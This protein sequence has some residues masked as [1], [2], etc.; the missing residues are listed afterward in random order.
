LI[1]FLFEQLT[2]YEPPYMVTSP[3][4]VFEVGCQIVSVL[5]FLP[6]ASAKLKPAHVK[7]NTVALRV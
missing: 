1:N 3:P 2:T 7:R 5:T 6:G 4:I